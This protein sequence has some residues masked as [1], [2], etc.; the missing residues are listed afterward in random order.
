[1]V[2]S[3]YNYTEGK[4]IPEPY[5]WTDE[6]Y[7]KSLTAS[8]HPCTDCLIISKEKRTVLFPK[9]RTKTGQGY[10]FV[11]GVWKPQKDYLENMRD[12]FQRETGLD[13][14]TE[15]FK[16]VK[17]ADNNDMPVRTLW[18][19]GRNDIHFIFS[20]ELT[21]KEIKKASENLDSQEYNTKVG[22]QEFTLEELKNTDGIR[23]IIID[24]VELALKK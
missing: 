9:R 18:S 6:E 15:R 5:F 23:S 17:L 22:L 12:I 8:L 14:K 19:T 21:E 1:M 16:R 11:G 7:L 10:W 3:L 20:V 13:I 24:T 2:K 4:K